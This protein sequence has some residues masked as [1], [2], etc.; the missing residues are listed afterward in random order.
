[1]SLSSLE[2]K[3]N[4]NIDFN[5][6]K[7][8]INIYKNSLETGEFYDEIII[9]IESKSESINGEIDPVFI[10]YLLLYLNDFPSHVIFKFSKSVKRGRLFSFRYLIVQSCFLYPELHIS[11]NG[12]YFRQSDSRQIK[13]EYEIEN[14]Y[15]T[16]NAKL[17]SR[18]RKIEQVLRQSKRFIPPLIIDSREKVAHL[19]ENLDT[20]KWN[21]LTSLY[22]FEI[23]KVTNKKNIV[24][25]EF[26]QF[27]IYIL[28]LLL[29][30]DVKP[31][32]SEEELSNR[33]N[34]AKELAKGIRELAE[35]IAEHSKTQNGEIQQGIITAR[36]YEKDRLRSLKSEEIKAFTDSFESQNFFLDINIIDSGNF[37][38]REKYLENITQ[39][40][41]DFKE[42][43]Q[44]KIDFNKDISVISNQKFTEFYEINIDNLT[45]HQTNKLIS[46]YGLQ[47][48][49]HILKE[50]FKA[51]IKASSNHEATVIYRNSNND[52]IIPKGYG[53]GTFYNCIVPLNQFTSLSE[54]DDLNQISKEEKIPLKV[55]AYLSAADYSVSNY[56][57]NKSYKSEE[58]I[59]IE[60]SFVDK[61]QGLRWGKEEKRL[62]LRRIAEEF[63]LL[64]ER[65]RANIV[66]IN[67][68]SILLD[69]SQW[70]RLLSFL[71]SYFKNLIIYNIPNKIVSEIIEIR[72]AS[73]I[74]KDKGANDAFDFWTNHSSIVFYSYKYSKDKKYR[75]YGATALVGSKPQEF[76][77]V[78][79]QIWKHRYSFR[80]TF[81]LI[82]DKV[83]SQKETFRISNSPLF[84][85]NSNLKFFELVLYNA[86]KGYK[87]TLF[88]QSVQYSLNKDLIENIGKPNTNNK[89]YKIPDA[90]FKT[91]SKV[92]NEDYYYA[93]RMF[94]NSFFTTPLA[95]L[96][97][98]DIYSNYSEESAITLVGYDSYSELLLNTTRYFLDSFENKGVKNLEKINHST[99]VDNKFT[100]DLEQI[101]KTIVIVIPI[102]S[103]FST[104]IKLYD[105][106]RKVHRNNKEL[107]NK[108]KIIQPFYNLI[109]VADN[110]FNEKL[111]SPSHFI[112]DEFRWAKTKDP[113]IVSVEKYDSSESLNQKFLIPIY[114]KWYKSTECPLC[115][116]KNFKD[117]KVLNTTREVPITPNVNFGLPVVFND[118]KRN[119]LLDYE[120]SLFYKNIKHNNNK[121]LYYIKVSRLIKN[122][123]EK[124]K[125]RIKSFLK[126]LKRQ[127]N[128]YNLLDKK[129]V[130]VTPSSKSQSQFIHLLNDHVFNFTANCV[131]ISV[132]E[133]FI[134]NSKVLYED[135]IFGAEYVIYIDDII[136]TAKSFGKINYLTTFIRHN[137]NKNG[138]DLIITVINRMS[139]DTEVYVRNQLNKK[140]DKNIFYVSRLHN[141]SI[142]EPNE[143][144]PVDIE[145]KKY[146]DISRNS[147]LEP[148]KQ[149]Y[150]EKSFELKEKEIDLKKE[151]L[152]LSYANDKLTQLYVHDAIY[153]LF[154]ANLI[155]EESDY[156]TNHEIIYTRKNQNIIHSVFVEK[157]LEVLLDFIKE[158]LGNINYN[159]NN[160]LRFVVYKLLTRPPLTYYKRIK[161]TVFT[162]VLNDLDR[163]S[164]KASNLNS[165]DAIYLFIKKPKESKSYS[166]YDTLKFLL[167][168]AAQLGSN[169][170][171]HKTILRRIKVFLDNVHHYQDKIKF[172]KLILSK[173]KIEFDKTEN[174]VLKGEILNILHKNSS[175][176]STNNNFSDFQF[177]YHDQNKKDL[178]HSIE[179]FKNID[180]IRKAIDKW[181][182]VE[183]N[184]IPKKFIYKYVGYVKE[185]IHTHE[186]KA[187]KLR[188]VIDELDNKT[189]FNNGNFN[190]FLRLLRLEN[191]SSIENYWNSFYQKHSSKMTSPQYTSEP[192]LMNEKIISLIN[193]EKG[194]PKLNS[195]IN[196]V[197]CSKRTLEELTI[198]SSFINFLS[199]M[200]NIE[201][202]NK[203]KSR[204]PIKDQIIT[205]LSK[206]SKIIG[207]NKNKIG[208]AFFSLNYKNIENK[209]L[210]IKDIYQFEQELTNNNQKSRLYISNVN[211][212]SSI[213]FEMFK[214]IKFENLPYSISNFELVKK[215]STLSYRK[216]LK[217]SKKFI[218]E[219]IE[220]KYCDLKNIDYNILTIRISDHKDITQ[221]VLTYYLENGER[222]DE[223][224]LRLLLLLRNPLSQF[225]KNRYE[226]D[227][228]EAYLGEE[229]TKYEL[230]DLSHVP[231]VIDDILNDYIDYDDELLKTKIELYFKNFLLYKDMLKQV[232]TTKS[233]ES[234]VDIL[235]DSL[236]NELISKEKVKESIEL[237]EKSFFK[238]LIDNEMIELSVEIDDINLIDFYPNLM[239]EIC[240]ECLFNIAKYSNTLRILKGLNSK[241][242][243]FIEYKDE[244]LTIMNNNIYKMESLD[245]EKINLDIQNSD[246]HGLNMLSNILYNLFDDHISAELK[247]I[248]ND[249]FF[250]L[251]IPIK[252]IFNE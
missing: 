152:T 135:A 231:K 96:L 205:I 67:A 39:N 181:I 90:H 184:L 78:N 35:N 227:S 170:I 187:I 81:A 154:K 128:N 236:Q 87:L 109:L 20:N 176:L 88:E 228:L 233:K 198:D 240:I 177:D 201:V 131:N 144:F 188:K 204:M 183:E 122:D 245:I 145:R 136:S 58:I 247:V 86:F 53:F 54:I 242:K 118:R 40:K 12:E 44:L 11:I 19:F 48:F 148:L 27:E 92:H 197:L 210:S 75:R 129:I 172:Q 190:H 196:L 132:N 73:Y 232:T 202:W 94:Q 60:S 155:Q 56:V 119:K 63:L 246:K 98:K 134:N 160:N 117:E 105:Q 158:Y 140:F 249:T 162:W 186:T 65:L 51:F 180:V 116:P 149:I 28:R 147:S 114:S 161:E 230:G 194:D 80:N 110:D 209:N 62:I 165:S 125:S 66:S 69:P 36:L 1:M 29:S 52:Q 195:I 6:T 41:E 243:I 95:Y 38:I 120:N 104:S 10:S 211:S 218:E 82:K 169:S 42:L 166:Q 215:D 237:I 193:N 221:A 5:S 167:K 45:D 138:I 16:D 106:I 71:T 115:F 61:I 30:N 174:R 46:R 164:L 124:K 216:E 84:D 213:T 31:K 222:I 185:L 21:K 59:N 192:E 157:K 107:V 173:L 141:P 178:F 34:Y 72:T 4:E 97:A 244:V 91:G 223:D 74:P 220:V 37:S 126:S 100:R 159:N 32:F 76:N 142:Q 206:T 207:L 251:T 226:S 179:E 123:L 3:I 33:F 26:S 7:K 156:N 47:F 252:S 250:S 14:G 225:I 121:F 146:I 175:L 139:F 99:F 79:K 199:L 49:T 13:V 112:V 137:F 17:T 239:D 143:E 200:I 189:D 224:R 248:G 203:G 163:Y 101:H 24:I 68:E 229:K 64:P 2:L 22:W 153:S 77:Y 127:L 111:D 214:G 18:K 151:R 23:E 235:R 130:I 70:L 15:I 238:D 133:D 219:A 150:L 182:H 168:R 43:K 85:R 212:E 50:R 241:L 108:P 113:N 234:F 93:K 9:N 217:L 208:G 171:I 103:T 57:E 102:A 191:T 83:S 55:N 25:P 8:F 89:G